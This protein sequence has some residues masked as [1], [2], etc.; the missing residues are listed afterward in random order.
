MKKQ[1]LSAA[2]AT[3]LLAWTFSLPAQTAP[4]TQAPATLPTPRPVSGAAAAAEAPTHTITLDVVAAH[5]SE[6]PVT[7]LAQ[8]SFTLLDNKT[9]R[10]ITSFKAFSGDETPVSVILVID[11]VN[12]NFTT[13]AQARTQIDGFLKANDGH[14]THPTRLAIFTDTGFVIQ[15]APSRDG[16]ALAE[17]LDKQSIGLRDIRRSSGFYGADERTQLSLNTLSRLAQAELNLPGRKLVLWVS[18]GWPLLSGPRVDLDARQSEGIFHEAVELSALLRQ[19]RITLYSLSPIGAGESVGRAFSYEE[20]LKGVS[21]PGQ[22]ELGD[23]ALEV[24]AVQSGGQAFAGSNDIGRMIRSA[25]EDGSAYYEISFDPI[26]AEHPNEYHQIEL[27][28]S[29]PGLALRT[30]QGYYNQ[31]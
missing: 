25:Y 16:N 20:Y 15:P 7:G 24:L 21:K 4:Q 18:P 29:E 5:K 12:T 26:P 13:V 2:S 17:S 10:A 9:P 14:L 6:A 11:A 1:I 8:A 27:K 30:R 31:P 3:A 22:A 28:D 23:L 19:A